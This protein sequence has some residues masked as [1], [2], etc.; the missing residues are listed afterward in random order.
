V[1]AKDGLSLIAETGL[2][3]GREMEVSGKSHFVAPN[4]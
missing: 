2:N 4:A 3:A 1:V